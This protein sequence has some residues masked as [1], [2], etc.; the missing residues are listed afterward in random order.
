MI[1]IRR[2]AILSIITFCLLG[3]IPVGTFSQELPALSVELKAETTSISVME[4]PKVNVIISNRGSDPVVLVRPGDGSDRELRTP[5]TRWLI[6]P[7]PGEGDAEGILRTVMNCGNINALRREEVFTLAPGQSENLPMSV[8]AVFSKPGKYRVRFEYENRPSMEWGGI[9]LG[10]H[11][12]GTM[13][14]VRKS[15]ACKLTS[16][17]VIFVVTEEQDAT[18]KSR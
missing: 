7:V 12:E 15:T 9:V 14:R 1:R 3:A 17:E 16:N 8:W 5:L 4:Q 10:Q 13:L 11:H 2:A 6:E 18:D